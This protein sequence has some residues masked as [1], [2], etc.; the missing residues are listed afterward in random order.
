MVNNENLLLRDNI[1]KQKKIKTLCSVKATLCNHWLLLSV[2]WCDHIL[3]DLLTIVI[4]R[5]I[6]SFLVDSELSR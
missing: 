6:L 2:P 5:L 4:D 1:S 3:N